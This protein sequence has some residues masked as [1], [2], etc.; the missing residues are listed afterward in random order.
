MLV[1]DNLDKV[2]YQI[3]IKTLSSYTLYF[4]SNF[5]EYRYYIQAVL[6]YEGVK[7]YLVQNGLSNYRV[8]ILYLCSSSTDIRNPLIFKLSERDRIKYMN[9]FTSRLGI[10]MKGV[11]TLIE[12]LSWHQTNNIWDYPYEVYKQ[13]G[14]LTLETI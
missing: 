9:D 5:K 13:R 6:Y 1:I 12:E 8:E 4:P 10:S 7:F 2:V 3:D 11:N 14:I